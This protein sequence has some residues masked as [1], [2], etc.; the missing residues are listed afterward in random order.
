LYKINRFVCYAIADRYTQYRREFREKLLQEYRGELQQI[1]LYLQ[2]EQMSLSQ[3]LISR[4]LAQPAI[5]RDP[6]V[7][8]LVR[9]VCYELE[10]NDGE[11]LH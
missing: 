2:G 1:A 3:R 11:K 4:Y 6:K 7:H 5:L 9:E 10:T 8:E